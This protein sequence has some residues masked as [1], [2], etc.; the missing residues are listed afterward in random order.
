MTPLVIQLNKKKLLPTHK[1]LGDTENAQTRNRY[2]YVL[3]N[4]Q[5]YIDPSGL[6]QQ[7]VYPDWSWWLEKELQE[8]ERQ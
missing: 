3:N 7:N 6:S 8:A 2:T 4:P 1:Y 5:K